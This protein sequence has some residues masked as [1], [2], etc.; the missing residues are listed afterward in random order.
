MNA[1]AI[2]FLNEIGEDQDQEARIARI[3]CL[4]DEK[5]RYCHSV[6]ADTTRTI[7]TRFLPLIEDE[8]RRRGM[9]ILQ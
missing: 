7:D 6:F 2:D 1:F 5:L 4:S 3:R 9:S 8:M